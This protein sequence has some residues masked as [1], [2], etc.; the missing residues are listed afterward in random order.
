VPGQ[1]LDLLM[2]WYG[3]CRRANVTWYGA[4]KRINITCLASRSPRTCVRGFC[5]SEP[6]RIFPAPSRREYCSW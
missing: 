1:A 3:R 5:T 2:A 4:R 6:C